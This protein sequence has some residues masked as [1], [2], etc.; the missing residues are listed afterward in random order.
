MAKSAPPDSLFLGTGWSFPPSF[1]GRDGHHQTVSG[2]QDIIQSL[3][4]LFLTRPG[5]RVM[6]PDYGCALRDLV[7]EPM[8]DETVAAIKSTI[9]RAVVFFEPR[10]D[11]LNIDV[12]ETDWINGW[13]SI[14][15]EYEVRSTNSRHNIVLPFYQSEGTL[16]ADIPSM[17]LE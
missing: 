5:E 16:L 2:E 13:L 7:F 9:R 14:Q 10:I 17:I 11:L 8:N 3:T 15:L 4:I 12:N 1:D 6:H